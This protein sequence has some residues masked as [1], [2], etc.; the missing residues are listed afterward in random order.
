MGLQ[1]QL[2]DVSSDSIPLFLIANIAIC[3]NYLRSILFAFLR[4]LGL[5]R[6]HTNRIVDE[7]LLAAV[8]SGLAGLVLLSEQLNLN[9]RSSYRYSAAEGGAIGGSA[10]VVC[11]CTLK[12]GELVRRL[13]CCHVFHMHC[14]DGWLDQLKF[15]CPLCRSSL[16]SDE[17]VVLTERRVGGELV[18]W[19]STW[20][21]G[22]VFCTKWI[23]ATDYAW[24]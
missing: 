21:C 10:C 1:N 8:G 20:W 16:V 12:D 4:S 9:H 3:L 2:N 24:R 5:F 6:F 23:L 11:R 15:N 18:P 13:P 7:G 22:V 19:F 17:R 14:F